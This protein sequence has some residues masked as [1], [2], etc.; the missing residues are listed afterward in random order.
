MKSKAR[1]KKLGGGWVRCEDSNI[2]EWDADEKLRVSYKGGGYT[3][4]E[5]VDSNQWG[6]EQEGSRRGPRIPQED[7]TPS[8]LEQWAYLP[9]GKRS[10]DK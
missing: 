6:L 5:G 4:R 9:G 3:S 1:F 7:F 2:L 8:V 10:R